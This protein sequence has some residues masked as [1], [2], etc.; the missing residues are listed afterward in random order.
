M[1]FCCYLF[2]FVHHHHHHCGR[3]RSLPLTTR[4]LS[5]VALFRHM[6]YRCNLMWARTCC[7][8]RV[9][10]SPSSLLLV[11]S[12]AVRP[13]VG[14]PRPYAAH[15]TS[16][17][18]CKWRLLSF[19]IWISSPSMSVRGR[20]SPLSLALSTACKRQSGTNVILSISQKQSMFLRPPPPTHCGSPP[21]PIG[22]ACWIL[23]SLLGVAPC[24]YL[25]TCLIIFVFLLRI[26]VE[27]GEFLLHLKPFVLK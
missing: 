5:A 10:S 3:G 4:P 24:Q 12:V 9:K 8:V 11:C 7:T 13:S 23:N 6:V 22:L 15:M 19:G 17:R 27:K 21:F 18:S 1:V 25:Y 20:E 2:V 14:W 26:I 16:S